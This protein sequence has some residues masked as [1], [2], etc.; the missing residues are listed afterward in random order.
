MA[1]EAM[2]VSSMRDARPDVRSGRDGKPRLRL[3]SE[4]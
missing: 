1:I 2:L 3:V 4:A